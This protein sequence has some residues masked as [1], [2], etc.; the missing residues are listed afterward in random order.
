[1]PAER[2]DRRP[3]PSTSCP[4]L[5]WSCRRRRPF[6]RRGERLVGETFLPL[7]PACGVPLVEEGPPGVEPDTPLL[8]LGQPSPAGR[9]EGFPLGRAFHRPPLRSTR[10]MPSTTGRLG[11]GSGPPP[12]DGSGSGSSGAS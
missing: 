12:G 3:P 11:I 4:S 8:P 2:L 1:M 10:R 7:D 6:L 5:S 9:G